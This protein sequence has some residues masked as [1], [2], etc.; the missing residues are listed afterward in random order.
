MSMLRLEVYQVLKAL[1][2][3]IR[4]VSAEAIIVVV[5]W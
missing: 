2:P 4:L 3:L 1:K 5:D